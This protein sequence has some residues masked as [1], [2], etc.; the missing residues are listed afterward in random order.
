MSTSIPKDQNIVR[1]LALIVALTLMALLIVVVG[2]RQQPPVPKR[3]DAP[4]DQFSAGRAV[5]QLKEILAEGGPHPTGSEQNGAVRQRIVSAFERLGY[6][7]E[8]QKKLVCRGDWAEGTLTVCA[9]VQNIITRLLGQADG[10]ALMLAAHRSVTQ[11]VSRILRNRVGSRPRV[12][13]AL[14]DIG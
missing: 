12:N 7:V 1:S 13:R 11:G 3:V 14:G 2:L 4:P 5:V 6:A 9:E 10:P 8:V